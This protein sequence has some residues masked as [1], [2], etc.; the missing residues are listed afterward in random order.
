MINPSSQFANVVECEDGEELYNEALNMYDIAVRVAD[1]LTRDGRMDA[2][3]S[4]DSREQRSSLRRETELARSLKCDAFVALH[5]DATGDRNDPGGGTWSFYANDE[6]KR[7]AECIQMPLLAAIRSFY[8][9]VKFR[10]IR[11]HWKRLWVLHESPCPASLTEVLFHS[12]SKE[13]EML[14]DGKCQRIIAEAVA[15][16]ILA[17]FGLA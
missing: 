7:L 10:G 8:P 15:K 3:L 9:E 4:R 14:K 17:F 11:K 6:G 2:Y 16:G 1:A 12:N 5:S 13:R